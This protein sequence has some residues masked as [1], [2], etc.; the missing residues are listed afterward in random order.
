MSTWK[1]RAEDAEAD[2]ASCWKAREQAEAK[3]DHLHEVLEQKEKTYRESLRLQREHLDRAIKAEAALAERTHRLDYF[4]VWFENLYPPD[5]E[6][7]VEKYDAYLK[8]R[9]EEAKP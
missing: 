3:V 9:A 5:Y 6:R 8:A 1:A 2:L 7:C 4:E